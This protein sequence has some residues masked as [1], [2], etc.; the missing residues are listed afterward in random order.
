MEGIFADDGLDLFATFADGEDDAAVTWDLPARY[1]KI[2]GVVI[3]LQERDVRS[4]VRVDFGKVL[5]VSELDDEHGR[6]CNRARR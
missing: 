4:H 2:P 6:E 5:F 3:L 1:E